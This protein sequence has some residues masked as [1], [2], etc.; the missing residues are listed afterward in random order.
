MDLLRPLLRPQAQ[1]ALRTA[2]WL[3]LAFTASA[4]FCAFA[5]AQSGQPS[6]YEVKA[7]F[8]FNFTKFVEWP[9]SSFNSPQAPIVIGIIGEDPF[10]DN[11]IRIVA[12]QKAEGRAILII[13]YR[14]GDNLR[15]CHVLF[16]SASERQHSMEILASLQ[17]ASVLTVSDIDGFAEAGGMM[18]FVV[19][20]NRVHF[21]VNLDA[22]T[23]SK[24]HVSAKLLALARVINHNEAAR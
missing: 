2:G 23:Q 13:K 19:Q 18:Q 15:H 17:D 10:G 11:L 12:G 5:A 20:E 7:A 14:R 21:I 1:F 22:A 4:L 8:L 16:I 3:L 24:L 6:E 9:D